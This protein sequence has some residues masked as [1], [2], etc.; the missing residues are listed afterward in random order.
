[1]LGEELP[2]KW[3]YFSWRCG[4]AEGIS[5]TD[6]SGGREGAALKKIV[7]RIQKYGKNLYEIR[8]RF[9]GSIV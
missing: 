3:H 9:D 8:C 7:R 6:T 4:D 1:M 5:V 2:F